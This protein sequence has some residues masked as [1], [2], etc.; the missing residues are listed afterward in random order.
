MAPGDFQSPGG[1]YLDVPALLRMSRTDYH[2]ELRARAQTRKEENNPGTIEL[3]DE[4][5]SAPIEASVVIGS[6]MIEVAEGNFVRTRAATVRV[7]KIALPTL[8][9]LETRPPMEVVTPDRV[10]EVFAIVEA[11]DQDKDTWFLRGVRWGD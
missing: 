11:H 5:N 3:I 9:D 8:P 4:T 6:G 2:A 1:F 10:S 7:A